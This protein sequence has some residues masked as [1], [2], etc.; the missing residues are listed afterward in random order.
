MGLGQNRLNGGARPMG[1]AL[2]SEE[3]FSYAPVF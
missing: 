2:Q 3:L 1:K